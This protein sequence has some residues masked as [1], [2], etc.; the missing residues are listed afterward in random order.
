[1]SL[2]IV[3]NCVNSDSCALPPKQYGLNIVERLERN[4]DRPFMTFASRITG[5]GSVFPPHRV[6]NT[7]LSRE[8]ARLGVET[9]D[10]WI[11]ERTGICERRY[12][13][14]TDQQ[15]PNASL[16]AE[17]AVKALEMAGRSAQEIDQIILATCTPDA[18]VSS[19]A[20]WV[21]QKIGATRA[22]AI[23]INAAC[24]GFVYGLVTAAQ[25]IATGQSRTVLV[26]GSEVIH[27][28]LDWEDRSSCILFGDGAGAA[29]VEQVPADSDHRILSWHLSSDGKYWDLLYVPPFHQGEPGFL[30]HTLCQDSRLVMNGREI[31]KLAV[32]TLTEFALLALRSQG[33]SVQDVDWFVPHQANQRILEAVAQRLGFPPEKVLINVDRYAN[34]SAAT[35]PTVMDEAVR[36]GRIQKGQLLLLDAFGAGFTYGAML[37]RW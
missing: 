30:N 1:L 37:I 12:A 15:R 33:F 35:I 7:D 21:Q 18:L 9:N 20:C 8:L 14:L 3:E 16:A 25:F 34:T 27:P 29:V 23:D 10:K 22:W 4:Q 11:R 17:A 32:R 26:I 2:N 36:D 24:S 28:Y 13:D 5:T 6:T 19:V 31:F